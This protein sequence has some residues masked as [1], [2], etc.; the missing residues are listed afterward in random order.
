MVESDRKAKAGY[1]RF[2]KA[3]HAVLE[4]HAIVLIHHG[5]PGRERIDGGGAWTHK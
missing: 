2:N 4:Y 5:I 1:V 3:S